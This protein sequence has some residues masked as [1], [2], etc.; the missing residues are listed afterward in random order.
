MNQPTFLSL[1][2]V[3]VYFQG[4]ESEVAIA[5]GDSNILRECVVLQRENR[6]RCIVVTLPLPSRLTTALL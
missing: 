5:K 1:G 2:I 3:V 6:E 4:E